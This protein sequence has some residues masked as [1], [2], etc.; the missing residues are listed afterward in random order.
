LKNLT[1]SWRN[2]VDKQTYN[3]VRPK[4]KSGD[5]AFFCHNTLGDKLIKFGTRSQFSHVGTIYVLGDRLFLL[6]A[7]Y[8]GGVRM[9]PLSMRIPDYIFQVSI[10]NPW[11]H[12]AEKFAMA[13]IMEKYSLVEALRAWIGNKEGKGWICTKYV[14]DVADE[15]GYHFPNSHQVPQVFFEDLMESNVPY[16]HIDVEA[17]TK[18]AKAKRKANPLTLKPKVG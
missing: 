11:N 9:V 14:A 17:S 5:V 16:F 15:Q 12:K 10:K 1:K 6:E 2:T 3:D 4:L 7:S 18:V 13:H 8:A